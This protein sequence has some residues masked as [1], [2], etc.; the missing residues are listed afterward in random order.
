MD[1]FLSFDLDNDLLLDEE[2]AT[3]EGLDEMDESDWEDQ[4]NSIEKFEL[5]I[6]EDI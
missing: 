2:E 3:F 1:D 4:I 5:D 6:D